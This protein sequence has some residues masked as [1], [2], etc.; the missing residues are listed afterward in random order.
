MPLRK[1]AGYNPAWHV[2]QSRAPHC[3]HQNT[4]PHPMDRKG[5]QRSQQVLANHANESIK[6]PNFTIRNAII[7]SVGVGEAS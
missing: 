3:H 4:C 7:K 1:T 2:A 6:S 5:V